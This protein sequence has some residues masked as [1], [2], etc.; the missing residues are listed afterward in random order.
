MPAIEG[1]R[2][3]LAMGVANAQPLDWLPGAAN[4]AQEIGEWARCSNFDAVTVLTDQPE[5]GQTRWTPQVGEP[6]A[7]NHPSGLAV[8]ISRIR[9]ELLALLPPGELTHWLVLHFAG[10]GIR[11]DSVRTL[12][13]PT[14]WEQEN[15]GIAVE[16]LKTSLDFYGI[17]NLT[18]V[19]DAC[20]DF[21]NRPATANLNAD[22]V[23]PRGPMQPAQPGLDRFNAVED[24]KSAF[25]VPGNTAA[26]ARCILSGSLANAL[27]GHEPKA[28]SPHADGRVISDSLL[29]FI[30]RK[31]KAVGQIYGL[32]CKAETIR[33]FGEDNPD[34]VY[35]DADGPPDP[36][37]P[38][39]EWPAPGAAP[40][41]PLGFPAS[42]AVATAIRRLASIHLPGGM[43]SP[44]DPNDGAAS[45]QNLRGGLDL[46]FAI[47]QQ[48]ERGLG[49]RAKSMR[50]WQADAV[51]IS[52]KRD[53]EQRV[54]RTRRSTIRRVLRDGQKR[55]SGHA[56]LILS[57]GR[58]VRIWSPSGVR[59]LGQTKSWRVDVEHSGAAQIIVEYADGLF[60]PAV[61]YPQLATL[62]THDGQ[63]RI[64]GWMC[65]PPYAADAASLGPT[66]KAIA[67]LQTTRLSPAD[68]NK[69]AA[70]IRYEKHANPMLGAIAAYLYD[71]VGDRDN[72][73]RMAWYYAKHG[74]P[75]PYDIALLGLLRTFSSD[76][77][78]IAE[79]PAVKAT[80]RSAGQ[81][82]PSFATRSTDERTGAV[83]GICPWL[84]QGWDFVAAPDP[85]EMPLVAPLQRALPHLLD[86]SFTAL[87]ASGAESLIR[88]FRLEADR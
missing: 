21:A 83:G 81:E 1:R 55:I 78:L 59:R 68:V 9:E 4:A 72:I 58:P 71:Y 64:S 69:L 16:A 10:H 49:P 82:L 42:D 44:V 27:W 14:D 43:A 87:S 60:A 85:I 7:I 84:R 15:R 62:V 67:E 24:G 53:L 86:S 2:V 6:T 23:L 48:A 54:R 88:H 5:V 28:F 47:E 12:W 63:G 73:R 76:G 8:T 80:R 75:I 37:A 51:A 18:L 65:A 26:E 11:Q 74:Q 25:M 36:Q 52:V 50:T 20:R 56:N 34:M 45:L 33:W 3:C 22:A 19:S 13:L 46:A 30:S 41:Q 66:N 40:A 35:Y 77:I 79:I 29:R 61:V 31:T 38:P 32:E 70:S 57:G 17:E 39:V